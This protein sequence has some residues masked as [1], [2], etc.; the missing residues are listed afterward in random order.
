MGCKDENFLSET[1]ILERFN[2]NI[3][4][5][6]AHFHYWKDNPQEGFNRNIMGCKVYLFLPPC[7]TILDLIGT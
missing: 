6:K 1:E 5:C 3:M 4:G 2:R 7:Q